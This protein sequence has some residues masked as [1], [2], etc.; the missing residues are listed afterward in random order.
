M[1]HIF[2][3]TIHGYQTTFRQASIKILNH[4][5]WKMFNKILKMFSACI[6]SPWFGTQNMPVL[7]IMKHGFF[8]W[9]RFMVGEGCLVN[10]KPIFSK[11][12]L[13]YFFLNWLKRNVF[14]LNLADPFWKSCSN[15]TGLLLSCLQWKLTHCWIHTFFA[16]IHIPTMTH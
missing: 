5:S 16:S 8:E 3:S 10:R 7:C 14:C 13:I 15:N 12:Y 6:I 2:G 9:R 1:T 11:I 4:A